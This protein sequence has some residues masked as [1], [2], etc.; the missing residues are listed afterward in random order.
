[1]TAPAAARPAVR[2]DI[3]LLQL[4]FVYLL[5]LRLWFDLAVNPMGD[6]W[7]CS[8]GEAPAGVPGHYNA[9]YREGSMLPAGL[10]WD[11]F[12]NRPMPENCDKDGWV[13]IERTVRHRAGSDVEHD[14]VR[15]GTE[16]PGHWHPAHRG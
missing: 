2:W 6:E 4:V 15:E 9:C 1:M 16:L 10:T 11:P 5:G 13:A 12:G 14:C 3:V 8:D 7:V